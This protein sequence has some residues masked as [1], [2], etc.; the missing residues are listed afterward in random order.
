MRAFEIH[1]HKKDVKRSSGRSSVA[2][3]A[4]R[5]GSLIYDER[6]GKTHDYTKKQGVEFTRVYMPENAPEALKLD[7]QAEQRAALWNAVEKKENR[8]NSQTANELEIAFPHEFN[9]MQRREC[10]DAIARD[11]MQRY[12]C[13]VDVA[14]HEPSK[15]GDER[16]FHAHIMFTTRGFDEGTKDGWSKNKYRDFSHEKITVDGEKTTMGKQE[17]L[18]L[19]KHCAGVMN[20]IAERD[21]LEVKTEY[22]SFEKRGIDR[23]PTQKMGAD[24][25][26]LERKGQETEIGNKNREIKAVNDNK[27]KLLQ[28]A[29]ILNF[30]HEK[31][32][33]EIEK[34]INDEKKRI[35]ENERPEH[36]K[37]TK[38]QAEIF[39]TLSQNP[40]QDL[41]GWMDEGLQSRWRDN[42]GSMVLAG[43]DARGT[44]HSE[45][46]QVRGE[47]GRGRIDESAPLAYENEHQARV[48]LAE[49]H[50]HYA[51][52]KKAFDQAQAEA[53]NLKAEYEAAGLWQSMTGHK[54]TLAE[55]LEAK[56][57]NLEY[58]RKRLYELSETEFSEWRE[59]GGQYDAAMIEMQQGRA[60]VSAQE[61][62][63]QAEQYKRDQEELKRLESALHNRSSIDKALSYATG[64]TKM[65]KA[66]ID[67]IRIRNIDFETKRDLF[68]KN[69]AEREQLHKQ[70][71][72]RALSERL[73]NDNRELEQQRARDAKPHYTAAQMREY[74]KNRTAPEQDNE[75]AP[76]LPVQDDKKAPK[77]GKTSLE[78]WS[79]RGTLQQVENEQSIKPEFE[80]SAKVAEERSRA[81]ELAEKA[82]AI[83]K[84]LDAIDHEETQERDDYTPDR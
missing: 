12:N 1:C 60:A 64:K 17:L 10:A 41:R 67:Q 24:A 77:N 47:T 56:N 7:N 35:A 72:E 70:K 26:A 66:V 15:K 9:Q 53:E 39:I 31:Q 22:L 83:Q 30:E 21:G 55:E 23:E 73:A 81:Q 58:A 18:S 45:L 25:A 68:N 63:T 4:Y 16:N 84:R 28:S 54:K 62:D 76:A 38:E 11:L 52:Y 43:S 74:L 44:Q 20:D 14:L 36:S 78:E 65:Q 59:R 71:L 8:G 19:R 40:L 5:S 27:N 32:R 57:A 37:S 69:Q 80:Q 49:N 42:R 6:T 46:R 13:A 82:E 75:K 2:A 61:I 51:V 34:L 50:K 48:K 3:A 33:L 29:E 79:E